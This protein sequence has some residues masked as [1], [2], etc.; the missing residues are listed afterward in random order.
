MVDRRWTRDDVPDQSG[1]A[2]VV[3]GANTGLGFELAHLLAGR[4]ASVTLVCRSP[5][6][7]EE[8]ADRIRADVAHAR[9]STV[10]MDQGSL[11][12]VRAA[13][14]AITDRQEPIDLLVN[15]AGLLGSQER[16][17]TEDGLEATFATN[18]LG[19]FA[20]TGLLIDRV[21][22][23]PDSRIVT[24]SSIA[25]ARARLDFD[26]LQAERGY[27]RNTAYSRSK[28]ANLMFAYG[29]QHRLAAAGQRTRSLAAHP[30][31]SRT[32][33]TRGL[34][35]VGRFVYGPRARLLTGLIMQDKSIGVL[36]GARA[37]TDPGASGGDYYGPAGPFQLTGHPVR[38]SSNEQ[39][40]DRAAQDR[41]WTA[42]EQLTGVS[43]R[44]ST[45]PG[46]LRLD[47][48]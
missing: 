33:F 15:N 21:L 4:G 10:Q 41:L 14:A 11:A 18:H 30:G 47:D 37:A 12:S 9:V 44:L 17:T 16:R 34:G 25:N 2:A 38:V 39:S 26:D 42:S 7:A 31:Q 1:R 19:A 13:A 23:T 40:C 35:A 48:A 5:A 32:D 22:A 46:P 27:D 8:A 20:F 36:A 29:L 3:T 28:L 24:M 43:Y 45:T 6:K